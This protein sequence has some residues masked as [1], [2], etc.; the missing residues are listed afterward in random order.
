MGTIPT[1][2]NGGTKNGFFGLENS[3]DMQNYVDVLTNLNKNIADD[4]TLALN[5]G[6]SLTDQ[7][8]D[9]LINQ[10]PLR[11]DGLPNVFNVQNIEQGAQKAQFYQKDGENRRSLYLEVWKSAGEDC[12]FLRLPGVMIGPH[13]WLVQIISRFSILL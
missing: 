10:G 4:Y 6:A 12:C 7:M 2:L 8:N 3:W 13:S 9:A 11:N 1:L 5:V